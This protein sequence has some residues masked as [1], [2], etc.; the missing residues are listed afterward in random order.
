MVLSV[1]HLT[2]MVNFDIR[3]Y[4]TEQDGL[5]R[6]FD[7]T[8]LCV[9][10]EMLLEDGWLLWRWIE[11][12]GLALGKEVEVA[13]ALESFLNIKSERRLLEYARRFGPLGFCA[14]GEPLCHA[15]LAGGGVF[16]DSGTSVV[17]HPKPKRYYCAPA[18]R[19]GWLGEPVQWWFALG[20]AMRAALNVATRLKQA[21]RPSRQDLQVL[22][23][24]LNHGL[25]PTPLLRQLLSEQELDEDTELHGRDGDLLRRIEGTRADSARSRAWALVLELLNKWLIACPAR[26]YFTFTDTRPVDFSMSFI[27]GDERGCFPALVFQLAGRIRGEAASLMVRC[28]HCGDSFSPRNEPPEGKRSFCVTC[29]AQGWPK[30]YA[31]RDHYARSS[32][33][34]LE[35]RKRRRREAK[36]G[37]EKP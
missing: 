21:E 36:S 17:S 26:L 20:E 22:Y 29:R 16:E 13:G 23:R 28:F 3:P 11:F 8:R 37:K 1:P 30:Y 10:D 25:N 15:R 9:P 24:A 12:E 27:A 2:I 19:E 5:P 31:A 35:R 4:M 18:Q 14:H 6:A 34:I 7:V 33:E 32:K